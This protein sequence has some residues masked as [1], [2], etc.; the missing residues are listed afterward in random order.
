MDDVK[1]LWAEKLLETLLAYKIT[2]KSSARETPFQLA[3][4]VEVVIL[5][6]I[7]LPSF[8]V[9]HYNQNLN[10]EQIRV[11]LDFIKKVID[12]VTSK[13]ERYKKNVVKYY[14]KR[15]KNRYFL[16]G[17]LVLQRA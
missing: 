3:F 1:G 5:V 10:K 13:E 7:G 12:K 15:V 14:N 17:D 6:E 16:I 9:S 8:R 11:N 4:R 2:H